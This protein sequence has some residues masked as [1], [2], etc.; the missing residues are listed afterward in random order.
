[1]PTTRP[2]WSTSGPPVWIGLT[3][4]DSMD[5]S[6]SDAAK[7]ARYRDFLQH[8]QD[9]FDA[10]D[11][12]HVGYFERSIRLFYLPLPAEIPFLPLG[13]QNQKH[14][15]ILCRLVRHLIQNSPAYAVHHNLF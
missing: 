1:M 15:N 5:N 9:Q 6:A 11:F 13:P 14:F 8:A 2:N 12:T 3:Y 7:D 10:F 4:T